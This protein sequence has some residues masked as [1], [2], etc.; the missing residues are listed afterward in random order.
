MTARV[1][2]PERLGFVDV[3]TSSHN[4]TDH[5]DAETL[6]PLLAANPKLQ[7]VVPEANR[8]F[9]AE[10]LQVAPERLLGVDAGQ[11]V[12]VGNF[13]LTGIPAAHESLEKDEHGHC[14]YLGYLV[15]FGPWSVYHSGDT[16]RYDGLIGF[17]SQW[18]I[19]LALLPINGRHPSRRVAGNL[20]GA[21]AALLAKAIGAGVVI[22]CHYEMFEF[23]TAS[24]DEFSKT[25]TRIHQPFKTLRA[26]ERWSSPMAKNP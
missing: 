25:A 23:N 12:A 26:G 20:D 16:I 18:K 17:L 7:L 3:A 9:V 24:P 19:D 1:I 14:R 11:A 8:Q 22:P 4:H 21:E 13:K 2:A 10:R 15:E 5:L 6:C